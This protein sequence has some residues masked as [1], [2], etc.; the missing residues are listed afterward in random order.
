MVPSKTSCAFSPHGPVFH[1]NITT[2]PARYMSPAT[3]RVEPSCLPWVFRSR[4]RASTVSRPELLAWDELTWQQPCDP[5]LI[6][7]QGYGPTQWAFRPML[8]EGEEQDVAVAWNLTD[9]KGANVHREEAGPGLEP[10]VRS[11]RWPGGASCAFELPLV[12][13][14]G[15]RLLRRGSRHHGQQGW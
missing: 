10:H 6:L 4:S 11:G 2:L 12:S 15:T 9:E 5:I 14:P 7:Q 8:E 13:E 3:T 1:P